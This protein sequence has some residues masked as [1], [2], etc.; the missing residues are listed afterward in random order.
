MLH[1]VPATLQQIAEC[2]CG[3]GYH[4]GQAGTQ[5]AGCD[6]VRGFSRSMVVHVKLPG[7][8]APPQAAPRAWHSTFVLYLYR[9]QNEKGPFAQIDSAPR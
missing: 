8:A 5:V 3:I 9:S 1:T 4:R 2:K 7:S 6:H